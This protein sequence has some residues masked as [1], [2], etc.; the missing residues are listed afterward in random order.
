MAITFDT[1]LL[2]AAKRIGPDLRSH[3]AEAERMGRLPQAMFDALSDA[4]LMSMLTSRSMGGLEVDPITYAKVVEQISRFD[5]AAGWTLT[6]PLL[7][8]FFCSRLPAQGA[9]EVFGQDPRA[10]I[11]GT[12]GPPLK[13]VPVDGGYQIS[14]R[15][16]LASN[17]HHAVWMGAVCVVDDADQL[18]SNDDS[19]QP[20]I[21]AMYPAEDCRILDTWHVMGMKGTG[22]NDIEVDQ[23]FVP[24]HRTFV[25]S[26]DFSLGPRFK[27]ELYRF[28][29]IGMAAASFPALAFGI[30]RTAIDE[31]VALAKRKT[32]AGSPTPLWEH[33]SAQSK[34]A[35]AEAAL[36]SGQ[37]LLYETLGNSWE[38]TLAGA[39]VSTT[40]R[41]D[42]LLA[43][44]NACT[45]AVRAVE[46]VHGMAGTTGIYSDSPL[47]RCFRDIQV[48]RHQRSMSE[49][50]YETFGR[51]L[52]GLEP[53]YPV[54]SL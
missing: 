21:F 6:I 33:P 48:V 22:S 14:G 15:G 2:E 40:L 43:A 36:R 16:A 31:A 47:E 29:W 27:G 19:S 18:P 41:A 25:M 32:P 51:M 53:Y 8:A 26:P 10:L 23:S 13:A 7:W 1:S 4:G 12:L 11:A 38:S 34:L 3:G 17:C 28:P 5:S 39:P 52:F 49:N 42:L 50:R 45:C 20:A 24:D 30:A 54:V 35:Q 44:A 9:E 37:A 46:L